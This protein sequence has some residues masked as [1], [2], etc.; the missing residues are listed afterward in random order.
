MHNLWSIGVRDLTLEQ[1]NH[2]ERAGVLP[3]AFSLLHFV[4]SEDNA[5]S[6][7]LL[8][9]ATVW[10]RDRW[11]ERIGPTVEDVGRGTPMAVAESLRFRDVDAWRDYQSAVFHRTEGALAALPEDRLNETPLGPELPASMA[12]AFISYVIQPSSAP[13]LLDVIECF[14]Y[15]HGIRHLGELE[16]ARALVGL[17]G[18]S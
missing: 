2:Y 9:D 5:T 7:Y 11:G 13:T 12:G 1:V 3:I 10:E 17:S 14:I 16:H 4:R 15:Q 18:T 8:N 6:R